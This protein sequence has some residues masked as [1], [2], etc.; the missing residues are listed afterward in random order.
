MRRARI[1]HVPD[2]HQSRQPQSVKGGGSSRSRDCLVRRAATGE[3]E[4]GG[5]VERR[6]F[7]HNEA[8]GRGHLGDRRTPLHRNLQCAARQRSAWW[9]PRSRDQCRYHTHVYPTRGV[10]T[11]RRAVQRTLSVMYLTCS[12]GMASTIAVRTTAGA[13]PLIVMLVSAYS[14]PTALTCT[15]IKL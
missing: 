3:V 4:C 12:T 11:Q 5:S 13:S 10:N 2:G 7:A 9:F 8:S 1:T 6:F 15:T 14:F